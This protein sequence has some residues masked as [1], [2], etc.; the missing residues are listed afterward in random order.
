MSTESGSQQT[1]YGAE[2][3]Y[4]LVV[5]IALL[6]PV[7]ACSERKKGLGMWIS[8]VDDCVRNCRCCIDNL[9]RLINGKE[10]IGNRLT[11]KAEK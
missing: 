9:I 1:D 5:T 7:G 8:C 10:I 3:T 11:D 6:G 4:L 2:H